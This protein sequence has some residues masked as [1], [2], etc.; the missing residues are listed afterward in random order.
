MRTRG[1][2]RR[3]PIAT[4]RTHNHAL[5]LRTTRGDAFFIPRALRENNVYIEDQRP[6]DLEFWKISNDHISGM[7]YL[8]HFHELQSSFGGI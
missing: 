4:A 1:L 8:I 3:A 5:P 7:C 6:T 2:G